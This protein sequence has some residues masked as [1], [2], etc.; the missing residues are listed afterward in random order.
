VK[1]ILRPT[2]GPDDW[3][4][5]LAEPEKQW[6][7]GYSAHSLAHCWEQADGLPQSV[8]A[9][10][11]TNLRYRDFEPLLAIPELKVDLPGGTRPSQTDLWLL[12]RV[13]DGLV[14]VAVEGKAAEPFGPTVAE[15]STAAS[16][17]KADRLGFLLDLLRL[18]SPVPSELRYQLLH[19]TVS[20]IL[21]ARRFH[22][23]HAAMVVHSFSEADLWLEDFQAFLKVFGVSGDPGRVIEIPGHS[24]PTLSL[25]WVSGRATG[26]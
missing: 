10:F 23:R 11:Q 16:A 24:D 26:A 3:K 1:L 2:N 9:V 18:K 13:P 21:M 12:G 17:G 14:S 19:R 6:K 22:A 25:A 5:F 4:Q 7:P 8:R 15:W 20:S